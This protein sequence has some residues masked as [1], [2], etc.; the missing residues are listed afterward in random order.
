MAKSRPGFPWSDQQIRKVLTRALPVY[1]DE[2]FKVLKDLAVV[3]ANHIL[4][5]RKGGRHLRDS[6]VRGQIRRILVTEIY[7]KELTKDLQQTPTGAKT[8]SRICDI[9]AEKYNWNYDRET[10]LKD[11]KKIGT[12][13]LRAE[14]S[15]ASS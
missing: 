13:K 3:G 2:E 12:R 4:D 6:V 15:W 9:L 10:I 8:I 5:R 1:S 11:V 7:R 14:L